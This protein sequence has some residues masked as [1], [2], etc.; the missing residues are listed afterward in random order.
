[1]SLSPADHVD[2]DVDL[3]NHSSEI[4]AEYLA[5]HLNTN[6]DLLGEEEKLRLHVNADVRGC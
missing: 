6:T 2:G 4:T 1:M 3:V 5:H